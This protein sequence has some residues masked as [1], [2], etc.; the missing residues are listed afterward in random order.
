MRCAFPF[1]LRTGGPCVRVQEGTRNLSWA[2]F[3]GSSRIAGRGVYDRGR[4][5]GSGVQGSRSTCSNPQ[6]GP[7]LSPQSAGA[8]SCQPSQLCSGT[9]CS[10]NCIVPWEPLEHLTCLILLVHLLAVIPTEDIFRGQ[11]GRQACGQDLE[12]STGK[13]STGA[14]GVRQ[15]AM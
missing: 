3:S 4:L 15:H 13:G 11:A 14:E 9:G 6:G 2:H 1:S 7:S 5:S 8:S 10:Q 12:C